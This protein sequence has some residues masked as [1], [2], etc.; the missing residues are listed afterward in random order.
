[1]LL[2]ERN[3]IKPEIYSDDISNYQFITPDKNFTHTNMCPHFR[4]TPNNVFDH[5]YDAKLEQMQGDGPIRGLF[6]KTEQE[7]LFEVQRLRDPNINNV[8]DK[9]YDDRKVL[10]GENPHILHQ[11]ERP[12]GTNIFV[13]RGID[14]F[15]SKR[16]FGDIDYEMRPNDSTGKETYGY[17][18]CPSYTFWRPEE[19]TREE[20][21]GKTRPNYDISKQVLAGSKP[22]FH[23]GL[24]AIKI[25]EL[26][27]QRVFKIPEGM[28]NI[29]GLVGLKQSH[30][31]SNI[32]NIRN[33]AYQKSFKMPEGM[34]NINGMVGDSFPVPSKFGKKIKDRA[35]TSEIGNIRNI[36]NNNGLYPSKRVD[37]TGKNQIFP[38]F[39]NSKEMSKQGEIK[40]GMPQY[41]QKKTALHSSN[42]GLP[43]LLKTGSERGSS[44]Q[45]HEPLLFNNTG[46]IN[47]TE[48]IM[49]INLPNIMSDRSQNREFDM[50]EIAG[51]A[52]SKIDLTR[53]IFDPKKYELETT[54]KDYL[55]HVP[56]TQIDFSKIYSTPELYNPQTQAP[57]RVEYPNVDINHKIGD[58]KIG[59]VPSNI[60]FKDNRKAVRE[61]INPGYMKTEGIAIERDPLLNRYANKKLAF[62]QCGGGGK[63]I[64]EF[65]NNTSQYVT[66][67]DKKTIIIGNIGQKKIEQKGIFDNIIGIDTRDTT[68]K[69]GINKRQF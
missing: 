1:M 20:L 5:Q 28:T 3:R 44:Y 58:K 29:N 14:N 2:S 60:I 55:L 64:Q 46:S 40:Q 65:D 36:D 53:Q 18:N 25:R 38:T 21:T 56:N 27:N 41:K 10:Y 35:M 34:T 49:N 52:G 59:I 39:G 33:P 7:P 4:G 54:R 11:F 32:I 51:L 67:P 30:G 6:F 50:M 42:F 24:N 63:L 43:I 17:G 13:G 15:Y 31:E 57:K 8:Y 16:A 22:T 23:G 26:L 19:L 62:S 12:R 37:K 68:K 47:K 48:K 45:V 61:I 66:M 69:G 9:V